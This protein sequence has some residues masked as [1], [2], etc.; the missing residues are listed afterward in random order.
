MGC[1]I[2]ISDGNDVYICTGVKMFSGITIGDGAIL[3]AYAVIRE[4]V[5]PYAI[6]TG[7]PSKIINYRYTPEQI[8]K[9]QDIKWWEWSEEK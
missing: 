7:N 6:V 2:L 4:D 5:P 3:G 1:G 8:A 9:L